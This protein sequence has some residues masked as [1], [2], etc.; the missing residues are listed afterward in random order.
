MG[1]KHRILKNDR[2]LAKYKIFNSVNDT[3]SDY[4]YFGSN[5]STHI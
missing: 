4:L 2:L 3:K 5:E 1:N